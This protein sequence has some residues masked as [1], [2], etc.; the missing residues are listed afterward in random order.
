MDRFR[1]YLDGAEDGVAKTADWAAAICAVPAESIRA[2]AQRMAAGRCMISVSWSLTRQHHGEQ[3]YWAAIAVAAMLGQIGLPGG[4]VSFGYSTTNGIGAHNTKIP[5]GSLPQGRNASET[6]IPVAR[7]S[8]MLLHPGAS[9]EFDGGRYQYP[10]IHLVYWAGGNPFH[11][12]QD[13]NRMLE[14]WRKPET[15]VVN[16]WCWNSMAKFSDIVLPCTTTLERNDLGISPRDPYVIDMQQVIE[17]VAAS[18]NDYDIFTG[19]ARQMGLEAEFTGGRDEQQWIESIYAT[20]VE[21]AREQG[22]E[23]P[24]YTEFRKTGWFRAEPPAQ[25]V[26][27]LQ[28][29]REDP[30]ASPLTTPSGKIEIF[31]EVV[32]GFG[33]DDC[34]GH[35][36]WLEPVEWLGGDTADYPLHLISNQ[37]KTKLHSQLDHGSHSRAAKI[38][39]REPI[40]LH[41]R[42][43][44]ARGIAQGDVVR[45]FNRRG[46]CLAGAVVDD[47]VMPGVVQMSTG[48]W[49]DPL[50]PG[51]PGSLCKHGNPNVLTPDLGTSRLAQGPIAHTC[52]VEIERY[53]DPLPPVT[54]YDPPEILK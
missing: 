7:I 30:E 25:P 18:R 28:A 27:M 54:A 22:I 45:V 47:Q 2:L 17:P 52:L 12:H 39:Q 1:D 9:F 53:D 51:Q 35:P 4:G 3:P 42:D 44:E 19:I 31:S 32:A 16:D 36:A 41:P 6:F 15:I 14:A 37:P 21:R 5:G 43:A 38:H 11:H 46:A 50:E 20:T 23:M 34:P 29:F 48:A 8:D 33:Y 49:Y 24:D 26:V 40:M 13:L 10:D